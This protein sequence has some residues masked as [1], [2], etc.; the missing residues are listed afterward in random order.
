MIKFYDGF[1]YFMTIENNGYLQRNCINISTVCT[2]CHICPINII[3][4]V[5]TKEKKTHYT[6]ETE[7]NE[8][9]RTIKLLKPEFVSAVEKEFKKI[10][11]L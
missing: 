2:Y 4:Q 9:K 6:Y 10:I 1:N 8:A 5:I 11:K 7:E 3:Y